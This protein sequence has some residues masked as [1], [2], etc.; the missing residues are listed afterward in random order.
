MTAQKHKIIPTLE[1][2][3]D[4]FHISIKNPKADQNSQLNNMKN[5]MKTLP[6]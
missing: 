5:N 4:N 3:S 6:T 1:I 2:T